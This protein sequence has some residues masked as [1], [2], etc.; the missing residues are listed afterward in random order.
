M[1]IV[2]RPIS[3]LEIIMRLLALLSLAFV[4][5]TVCTFTHAADKVVLCHKDKNTIE[6]S[7]NAINAH[8]SHGDTV[9]E[10]ANGEVDEDDPTK[11]DSDLDG[12]TP[13]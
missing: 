13:C 12:V 6:V 7:F 8:F 4:A 2:V 9:G 1:S 3:N 11:L 10:C 5:T